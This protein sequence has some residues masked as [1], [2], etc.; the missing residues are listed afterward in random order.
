MAKFLLA[1]YPVPGHLFP[2][3][4]LAHAL[5]ER[6]HQV[7]IYSGTMAQAVVEGEGFTFFPYEGQMDRRLS[8]IILPQNGVS[9]ASGI[10]TQKMPLFSVK[11]I[12]AT[13]SEWFL[14]TVPEQISDLMA[15]EKNWK[16][17]VMV[18]DIS[19]FGPILILHDILTIPIAAFCVLPAYPI[20]GMDA[21]TW[22][23]GLSPPKNGFTRVQS[24]VEKVA[25]DWVLA[26]FR[27]QA[28]DL[29]QKYGLKPIPYTVMAYSANLPL[30]LVVGS[31]ELDYNRRDLPDSVYYVGPCLWHRSQ[32]EPPP[33]W[34]TNLPKDRPVIHVTEGT[35]HTRR[36]LVLRAAAQGLGDLTV[37]VIM[38]TGKHRNPA[39]LDLGP[40]APNIRVEQ[41]VPHSDL[42]PVT[43]VV[44]STGGAGTV[45]TALLAGVPLIIVPTAW[46]LPENAQRVV[47][48][49]A[50]IR[51]PPA[52][53]SPERLRD[54]VETIL[55]DPA[56]R[57]KAVEIG[58]SLKRQGG[59]PRAAELL[60]TLLKGNGSG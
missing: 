26:D 2:N 6:R 15:I 57:Q 38:S 58:A 17:D 5:R 4:A 3:V 50:G 37:E 31:P 21:P 7:A 41:F 55:R 56:Y 44:I 27:G 18:T 11:Q 46:D 32:H 25:Q 45:L 16:P 28:N 30:F 1:C 59:P 53:C 39:E 43:D 36:P 47:E 20:A 48:A 34:L 10:S 49:G 33:N 9:Q 29:R 8:Q 23:R 19:L 12:N 22:G 54:A 52:K 60:E 51:I 35:I 40:L 24:W 13:L 14:S 42:F